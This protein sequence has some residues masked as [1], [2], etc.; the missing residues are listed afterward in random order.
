MLY[1]YALFKIVP[2]FM[3]I[4]F[5]KGAVVIKG[6]ENGDLFYITYI[7][8][9]FLVDVINKIVF[10]WSAK[11]GCSHI[12]RI[13]WFLQTNNPTSD[14]HTPKDINPLPDDIESYVTL[15]F[16]RNPY[17]RIVSGFLD[18]YRKTGQ[19]RHLWKHSSV[20]FSQFVDE[21]ITQ[22][23]EIIDQHHFTPQTTCDFD[24]KILLS[25]IVKFYDICNIDYEYIGQLYNTKIPEV[26]IN[27]KHG[28]ER[29]LQ[30]KNTEGW[31]K[32]VYDLN[33]DD[34]IDYN[35]DIKYFYNEEI[36][37]KVF[38]F[39]INDFNFFNENGMGF[40]ID[41]TNKYSKYKND[42]QQELKPELET[43]LT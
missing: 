17:K 11:C 13:Y 12:K 30:I 4:I 31:D 38:N 9:F 24:K 20:T 5:L 29:A 41:L 15:I 21:V 34:Y 19:Y 43:I 33:V 28:H 32:N 1:N 27:L 36:R 22:N 25:K 23:W 7:Y 10:A 16:T 39:Y 37:E 2:K 6:C 40:S 3:S 42:N 35:V 18:K 8:M 14:I 26:V